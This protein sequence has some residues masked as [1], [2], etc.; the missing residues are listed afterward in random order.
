M[1]TPL[2]TPPISTLEPR[3]VQVESLNLSE[4]DD[5]FTRDPGALTHTELVRADSPPLTDLSSPAISLPTETEIAITEVP[6]PSSVDSLDTEYP[7]TIVS[8]PDSFSGSEDSEDE[9]EVVGVSGVL[10]APV[11]PEEAQEDL[12]AKIDVERHRLI[13]QLEKKEESLGELPPD[14]LEMLEELRRGE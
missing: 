2:P 11:D 5:Q 12:Q 3:Y 8:K 6:P 13:D 10:T 4:D 1:D 7:T 9:D 14:A